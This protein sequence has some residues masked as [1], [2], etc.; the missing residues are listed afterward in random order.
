MD[1][2]SPFRATVSTKQPRYLCSWC[3]GSFAKLY[4]VLS[5]AMDYS[6]P[7]LPVLHYLPEFS[8]TRVHWTG[9]AIQSSHPLV[10]T[11]PP[12]FNQITLPSKT[13]FQNRN[14]CFS[15]FF[16][17]FLLDLYLICFI[18]TW[19]IG[20]ILK[21]KLLTMQ[22]HSVFLLCK[23]KDSDERMVME[24]EQNCSNLLINVSVLPLFPV[25]F[26]QILTTYKCFLG[27]LHK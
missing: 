19:W 13:D 3:C 27:L 17:S 21:Y 7:G 12:A 22:F 9:D 6:T 23:F 14:I 25:S 11:S 15:V 24:I 26:P 16:L 1:Y 4:P 5:N 18:C 10:P 2:I 8:Q 20:R